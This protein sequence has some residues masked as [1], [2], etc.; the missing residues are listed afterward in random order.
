MGKKW[1]FCALAAVLCLTLYLP[2]RAAEEEEPDPWAAPAMTFAVEHGLL[3][4][5]DMRPREAATRTVLS[6]MVA[7][8]LDSQARADLSRFSDAQPGSWYYDALSRGVAMGLF[9]GNGSSLGLNSVF[10][11]EQVITVMARCFGVPDG[12]RA[13]L[14]EFSDADQISDWAAGGGSRHGGRGLHPG[15]RQSSLPPAH[16]VTAGGGPTD[17]PFG[18]HGGGG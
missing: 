10:T 12:D 2:V 11:R 16:H 8:L 6:L 4:A 9:Q 7:E 3:P 13:V 18:G 17:L 1:I 14:T 15:R 5:D